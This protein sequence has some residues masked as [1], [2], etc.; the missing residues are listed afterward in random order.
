MSFLYKFSAFIMSIAALV[1]MCTSLAFAKNDVSALVSDNRGGILSVSHRGDTE[2][3]PENSLDAVLSASEKGAS[4][5]SVSVRMSKDGVPVLCEEGELFAYCDTDLKSTN[6]ASFTEL[7]EIPYY[8]TDGAVS[9]CKIVSLEKAVKKLRGK[10]ILILDN[11]WEYR[12]EIVKFCDENGAFDK[13]I[14]RCDESAK[15]IVSFIEETENRISVIGVYDGA[16]VMNA[17]SH[18]NK[19]SSASQSIVQYESKN[20]FNE[21]YKNFTAKRFS[22][23]GKAR[24]LAPMYDKDLCGQREDNVSGWDEMIKRGFSVIETNNIEGLVKYIDECEEEKAVL[25]ALEEKAGKVD[26]SLY[27]SGSARNFTDAVTLCENVLSDGNA[28]LGEIQDAKSQL[29]QSMKMLTFGEVEDTQRGNLN[30]TPV[31]VICTVVFGGLIL[32]GEIYVVKKQKK[33]KITK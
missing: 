16:V 23:E 13:V 14:I 31:K 29:V 5:I 11:A 21:M 15:D 27:S 22:A 10:S 1:L 33:E 24:A 30:V 28:S 9:E 20:Y 17:I 6:D 25:E 12:N 26:I 4:M 3:Y 19:L 7:S 8:E 18:L 2:H 32:A